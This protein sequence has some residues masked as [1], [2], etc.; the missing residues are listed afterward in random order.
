MDF[1]T[2]ID[3]KGQI[4]ARLLNPQSGNGIA[5]TVNPRDCRSPQDVLRKAEVNIYFHRQNERRTLGDVQARNKGIDFLG[6]LDY[7]EAQ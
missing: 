4:H 6:R 5:V 3:E 2:R 1:R 7:G